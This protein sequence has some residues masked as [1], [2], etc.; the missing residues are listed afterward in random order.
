MPMFAEY[1]D[2]LPTAD[3][4]STHWAVVIAVGA[5][6]LLLQLVLSLRLYLR[7][8]RHERVLDRLHDD[9]DR[10]GNGRGDY[11]HGQRAA[12]PRNFTWLRWVL[13]VFPA[14]ATAPAGNFTRDQV[15]HELDTRIASD[16]SYLLLQR[17]GIMAPLLG[18]VL[19]VVGFFW[20]KVDESGEQSLQT[21]LI[22]VMPLVS[23]VGAG[24]VLALVNQAL[25]QAVGGRLERLRMTARAWFD[26]AIWRHVGVDAQ[27]A[28]VSAVAALDKFAR[29]VALTADQHAASS[30]QLEVSTAS[31]RHAA[32]QF[33]E[34]VR[35]FQGEMKGIP[36]ALCVL[37]DA[38]AASA[39]ALQELLPVGARAVSNLD[40]S[41][42]AFRSTVDREFTEAA[43]LHYRSSKALAASVQH[44]AESTEL[45]NAAAAALKQATESTANSFEQIDHPL[46]GSRPR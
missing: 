40:V 20:L 6:F 16:S 28:T 9:L 12:L 31:M 2:Y 43:K 45:L 5:A 22:A 41:V 24:A 29:Q 38:T 30:N 32:W 26:A 13:D 39:N 14:G 4:L 44:I 33:E 17:L 1:L 46:T 3:Q 11:R 8:R 10:G 18:V 36:Q 15:L 42:A 23:G 19:T 21:I 25:L 7:A 34:V 35:A 37:R 27:A